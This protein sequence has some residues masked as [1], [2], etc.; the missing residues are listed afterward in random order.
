MGESGAMHRI[1]LS[2]LLTRTTARVLPNAA[3]ARIGLSVRGPLLTLALAIGFDL[4]ARHDIPV[5]HPF[6]FLLASVVYS[7]YSGGIRPGLI[8]GVLLILYAVHFLS[9]PGLILHYTTGNAYTLA[10]LALV[11]P[12]TTALV[13]QLREADQRARAQEISRQ[14]AERL[15]RRLGFFAEANVALASSLDYEVTMRTLAR[16]IV[17]TLADWCAIHVAS[18]QGV[19]Q[20]VAGAH[21]DPA[22]DLLVRALCEYNPRQPPFGGA[23]RQGELGQVTDEL[24]Q[25]SSADA[26]QLKLFRAL[27]PSTFLRVPLIARGETVGTLTLAVGHESGRAYDAHGHR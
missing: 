21:R 25:A 17:P 26:E 8:S 13:S 9:T 1:S 18:E 19:L 24:L 7:S 10:G 14:E 6:V 23:Q 15:D 20:F 2:G 5:V 16:L 12:I 4:L 11:V 22:K 27:A 3:W